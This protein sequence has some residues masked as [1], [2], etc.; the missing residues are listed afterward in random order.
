MMGAIFPRLLIAP[1][2]KVLLGRQPL[3]EE[4]PFVQLARGIKDQ[5]IRHNS[6]VAGLVARRDALLA[7]QL[8]VGWLADLFVPGGWLASDLAS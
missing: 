1:K 5:R 3:P 6:D 2:P 7:R 8:E 4:D